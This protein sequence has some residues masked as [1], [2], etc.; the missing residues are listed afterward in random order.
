MSEVQPIPEEYPRVTPYLV[1]D[2]G[3][4][5]IDFYTSVL[6]AVERMRMPTQDGRIGHAELSIGG[7]MV[8]LS[9]MDDRNPRALGGSPVLLHVYVED[10]DRTYDQAVQ[11]GATGVSSVEDQFYGDR[12][13]QFDDPFGHRWSIATHVEDVSEEEMQRR[14]ERVMSGST[15]EAE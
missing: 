5:A 4:A 12:A 2:D 7:S 3:A 13:G 1:V 14:V 9:D 8:M 6:G 15:A 10:V 11:A